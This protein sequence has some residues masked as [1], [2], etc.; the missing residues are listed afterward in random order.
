M[1]IRVGYELIYNFPQPT[2]VILTLNI[3]H[4]ARRI[5]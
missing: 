2:P 4:R 3:T 5:F 1:Q